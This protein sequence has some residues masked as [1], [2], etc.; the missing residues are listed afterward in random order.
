ML[1]RG[2]LLSKSSLCFSCSVAHHFLFSS[3]IKRKESYSSASVFDSKI[4]QIQR[5][6]AALDPDYSSYQ[7]LRNAVAD[8]LVDRLADVKSSHTRFQN[9]LDLGSQFNQESL[10]SLKAKGGVE[11]LIQY[12]SSQEV[13][14]QIQLK[15]ES[16]LDN[17]LYPNVRQMVGPEDAL[18]F[19][20]EPGKGELDLV[21][22]N[23]ALHWVNDLPVTFTQIRDS[24]RPDGMALIS[25]FGGDTLQE[26][27]DAFLVAEQEREGRVSVRVSP[28]IGV[29]DAGSLLGRA[30]FTLPT[31]DVETIVIHYSDMFQLMDDLR[32]MGESNASLLRGSPLKRSTMFAAAAA[33]ESMYGNEDG[34]IPATFQVIFLTGWH[35]SENQQKP[36]TR[37]SA[38]QSLKN[39]DQIDDLIVGQP[40]DSSDDATGSS[41]K[42]SLSDLGETF[43]IPLDDEE[44]KRKK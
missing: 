2:G 12:D 24:L 4:K 30:Q 44:P 1:L 38:K 37:G 32:G 41:M 42:F 28:M 26:L 25:L 15:S 17:P 40:P 34:T 10:L 11:T 36:K 7:H 20:C 16:D 29:S 18:P 22:S 14:N 6:R 39:L 9:A 21:T 19:V 5:S 43:P 27:R 33:Y 8:L 13:L 35:P 3:S 23:L 31:I